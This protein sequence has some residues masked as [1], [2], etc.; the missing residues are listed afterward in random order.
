MYVRSL[1]KGENVKKEVFEMVGHIRAEFIASL[2]EMDWMDSTTRLRVKQK[3][4]MMKADIA[5]PGWMFHDDRF[6]KLYNR[7]PAMAPIERATLRSIVYDEF[8]QGH[9]ARAAA[10]NIC[11]AFEGNDVHYSTVSR[12]FE[13]L[14]SGDTTFGDRPRS[15][16]PSTVDDEALRNALDAKPNATTRESATTLAVTPRPPSHFSTEFRIEFLLDILDIFR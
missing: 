12:W 11:A 2:H 14:E 6:T 3:C 8:L 4:E 10:D 16:R 1:R 9:S 15:G 5:Y 7:L 13:R